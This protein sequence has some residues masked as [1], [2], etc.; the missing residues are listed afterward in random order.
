ME[1]IR[2]TL[3]DV[4][5][6]E[7]DRLRRQSLGEISLA[8]KEKHDEHFRQLATDCEPYARKVNELLETHGGDVAYLYTGSTTGGI[9]VDGVVHGEQE[10]AVSVTA[11][12]AFETEL[13]GKHSKVT[14]LDMKR[15]YSECHFNALVF[16]RNVETEQLRL[17]R[18]STQGSELL[19]DGLKMYFF[20]TL[21]LDIV[22]I[23]EGGYGWIEMDIQKL[24]DE[25]GTMGVSIK[26]LADDQ[27]ISDFVDMFIRD[28]ENEPIYS[29]LW[30]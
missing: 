2:F 13:E 28:A 5:S 23:S 8:L 1:E 11:F 24:V 15:T 26:S 19:D 21:G 12:F 16:A 14:V 18:V 10:P 3:S 20:E 4:S 25:V 9:E 17:F 22:G 30:A 7:Y 27:R 29:G 6:E